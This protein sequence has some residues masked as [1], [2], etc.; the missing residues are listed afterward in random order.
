LRRV[1][2]SGP[3]D[4]EGAVPDGAFG[5]GVGFLESGSGFAWKF[6]PTKNW[7]WFLG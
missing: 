4:C 6:L 5:A 2:R 3:G 7:R 1:D